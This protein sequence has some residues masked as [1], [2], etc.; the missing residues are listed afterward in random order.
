[1]PGYIS[2]PNDYAADSLFHVERPPVNRDV[3]HV[4]NNHPDTSITMAA[5]ALPKS[6]TLRA[7]IFRLIERAGDNGYTCDEMEIELNR[8]HQSISAT[9]NSL[10]RDEWIIDGGQRRQTRYGNPAIVWV[11]RKEN[12]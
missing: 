6:G 5:K 12:Q 2:G 1:M 7:T 11:A 3:F 4:S 8:S 9:F 10:K